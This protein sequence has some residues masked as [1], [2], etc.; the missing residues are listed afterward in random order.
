LS[1]IEI[2][3]GLKLLH[4]SFNIEAA[5]KNGNFFHAIMDSGRLKWPPLTVPRL[6]SV[7]CFV[8]YTAIEII[9]FV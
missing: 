8:R 6:Y 1:W 9:F 7:N 3:V 5:P 2:T 4:A